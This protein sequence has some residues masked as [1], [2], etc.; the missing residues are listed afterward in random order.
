MPSGLSFQLANL[1]FVCSWLLGLYLTS[2]FNPRWDDYAQEVI[3]LERLNNATGY[4]QSCRDAEAAI[5]PDVA[6]YVRRVG[7][8]VAKTVDS[9]P[10]FELLLGAGAECRVRGATVRDVDE[11]SHHADVQLSTDE[12]ASPVYY[13]CMLAALTTH[14]EWFGVT[15]RRCFLEPRLEGRAD[16]AWNFSSLAPS[17]AGLTACQEVADKWNRPL[18]SRDGAS[19]MVYPVH[20]T[21]AHI[22]DVAWAKIHGP[23]SAQAGSLDALLSLQRAVAGTAHMDAVH[24]VRAALLSLQAAQR[25]VRAVKASTVRTGA[26]LAAAVAVLAAV[27]T[28][29]PCKNGGACQATSHNG[30]ACACATGFTGAHCLH[31]VDD[32]VD[33]LCAN[34]AGCLDGHQSYICDC[35]PGFEGV[36]CETDVDDCAPNPCLF[37]SCVDGVDSFSC[38]CPAG[39]GGLFCDEDVLECAIN[40]CLNQGV[41]HALSGG[42]LVCTCAP[43]YAGQTCQTPVN[44]CEVGIQHPQAGMLAILADVANISLRRRQLDMLAATRA[45]DAAGLAADAANSTAAALAAIEATQ[46]AQL[47]SLLGAAAIFVAAMDN[48]RDSSKNLARNLKQQHPVERQ[49]HFSLRRAA[50]AEEMDANGHATMDRATT[51]CDEAKVAAQPICECWN[52]CWGDGCQTCGGTEVACDTARHEAHYL[53]EGAGR[54][55]AEAT[56]LHNVYLDAIAAVAAHQ[57]DL[58]AL[59]ARI[60]A[61][62]RG[63]KEAEATAQNASI[64]WPTGSSALLQDLHNRVGASR[65]SIVEATSQVATRREIQAAVCGRELSASAHELALAAARSSDSAAKLAGALTLTAR[66]HHGGTCVHTGGGYACICPPG[67]TGAYCEALVDNCA[68]APCTT[69]GV[70]T[71]VGAGHTCTCRIGFR[72]ELCDEVVD[73]LPV[74]SGSSTEELQ[75]RVDVIKADLAAK[76]Q[77]LAELRTPRGSGRDGGDRRRR[78]ANELALQAEIN[79]DTAGLAAANLTLTIAQQH[80][81]TVM[82]MCPPQYCKNGGTCYVDAGSAD[83]YACDCPAAFQGRTC[84]P[85]TATPCDEATGEHAL[86][87]CR[88]CVGHLGTV[89]AIDDASNVDDVIEGSYARAELKKIMQGF[90]VEYFGGATATNFM[91]LKLPETIDA[92]LGRLERCCLSATPTDKAKR[93]FGTAVTMVSKLFGMDLGSDMFEMPPMLKEAFSWAENLFT[94]LES[95]E[96]TIPLSFPKAITA[97][98][99]ESLASVPARARRDGTDAGNCSGTY[100]PNPCKNGGQCKLS[101]TD[102]PVQ[103]YVALTYCVCPSGIYGS[104]CEVA[105]QCENGGTAF[106]TDGVGEGYECVCMEGFSGTSCEIVTDYCRIKP[107]KS[108][109][110]A[111]ADGSA[112]CTNEPYDKFKCHCKAG[113]FG[114]DCGMRSTACT[115]NQ[116][117]CNATGTHYC[118]EVDAACE[119]ICRSG[120]SG[121]DCATLAGCAGFDCNGGTCG[122]VRG[123]P[124]CTCNS[125]WQGT[126]CHQVMNSVSAIANLDMSALLGGSDIESLLSRLTTFYL[127]VQC[128]DCDQSYIDL[129]FWGLGFH[130]SSSWTIGNI[131]D[132]KQASSAR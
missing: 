56:R 71:S 3:A 116:D 129:L 118:T 5:R 112:K 122:I 61:A 34:G 97:Q 2:W 65:T 96:T 16:F 6:G 80:N 81:G 55:A 108:G 7:R 39:R 33:N 26:A 89:Y 9:S 76:S 105:P 94:S 86:A 75:A 27:E 66:C 45:C 32:C 99:A 24:D 115:V 72:G 67:F 102:D 125:G 117:I 19:I 74:V 30:Y 113:N 11:L 21:G 62:T 63:V 64:A 48:V 119:A 40:P 124:Q 8:A 22:V 103:G 107:C 92:S 121:S 127:P 98:D 69:G 84:N 100:I 41:C 51:Q 126:Y 87:A 91:I 17:V 70:C 31:S 85:P 95:V 104:N 14:R 120:Y 128:A 18:G 35:K 42:G 79:A 52:Q 25:D 132:V 93:T 59:A 43:G 50:A 38:S 20:V 46:A 110:V 28:P 83:G 47:N 49:L 68:L 90:A 29:S 58:G 88:S 60:T 106:P 54:L 77:L 109:T 114:I 15:G 82:P 1:R 111:N 36:Y 57:L 73:V 23:L 13:R 123:E 37:G 4:L 44:E 53:C 10:P 78:V 12:V 131:P 130:P 101:W